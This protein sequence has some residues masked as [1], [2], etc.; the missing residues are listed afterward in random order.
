[1]VLLTKIDKRPE[2]DSDLKNV[3]KLK[4]LLEKVLP[5]TSNVTKEVKLSFNNYGL[6]CVWIR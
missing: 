1:M 6:V 4:S 5:K 2:I 3:Y